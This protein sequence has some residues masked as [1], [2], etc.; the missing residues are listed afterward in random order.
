MTKI[1]LE[2]RWGKFKGRKEAL[3]FVYKAG[4]EQCFSPIKSLFIASAAK[5]PNLSVLV[6]KQ[7][8]E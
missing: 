6:S 1:K 3:R 7:G 5:R 2:E 8:L 4:K